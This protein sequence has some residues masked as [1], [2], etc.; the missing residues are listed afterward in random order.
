MKKVININFQGRV[1]PIEET[2][3]DMLTKYVESLRLFFANE[4]GRDEIINDIEGRI[5]ELFGETLKKGSTCIT[6]ADV[7]TII[8]SM[9]RPEDFDDD[10]AKVHSQLGGQEKTEQTGNYQQRTNEHKRLYRD[11]N[12]KVVAGVCSGMANYFNI[13]PVVVRILTLLF[14][15]VTLVP[16]LILWVAVPSS[17]STVIGSQR[18]RLFRD[19]DNKFVAGVCSG[20]SQYF[21]INIWI[22][23]VLFLLPFLSFVFRNQHWGFWD[24]PSIL[25]FSFSPTSLVVYIILWI[26]LPEA[27]SAADKLEMKGE[28]V[29]L[30]NIKTTIQGDLVGFK[31][32]AQQFGSEIRDKAQ[33]FGETFNQKGKQFSAEAEPVIKRSRRNLGDIIIL[34]VKIFAY[35]IVGCI[36][37]SIVIALF[38]M[39]VVVTSLLPQKDFILRDG[40]QNIFAWGTLILFVWVPIVGIVT[41]I[42]RRL[43]KKRG[44]ST[45][46]RSSFISLWVIGIFCLVGLIASLFRDF[47]YRNYPTEQVL[48]LSNPSVKKLEIKTSSFGKFYNNNWFRMEPFTMFD[49]DTV[50]VRNIRLRIVRSDNDS[51]KISVV[52]MSNGRSRQEAEQNATKINF[53]FNQVDTSLIVNKGIAITSTDKFRNQRLVV[54]VAVPEGKRININEKE[55]WGEGFSF[56]MGNG[57]NF[58]DWENDAE[59][60]S[61]WWQ[62]NV[63]Y[64]MTAKGLD[65]VYKTNDDNPEDNINEGDNTSDETIEQFRKSKEQMEREKEQKIRELQKIEEELQKTIDTSNY[66]YKPP[67]PPSPEMPVKKIKEIVR[68]NVNGEVPNGINDMMMIKFAL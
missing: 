21:A 4:E 37:I 65:K 19:P 40:L 30:N 67:V 12:H 10:E 52:K 48:S 9:G 54:T 27:K 8:N 2:A 15:G 60:E 7:N 42:I 6:D 14:L 28:K 16:Y 1:I 33:E 51:F 3:Y 44:N 20:L 31:D 45:I 35:F 24:F 57:N 22:P 47:K 43:A 58:F 34:L 41:Y 23:R 55:G 53:L 61:F 11:E 5:A 46:I 49:G 39:G 62:P 64:V 68:N 59:G 29:D 26:V 13:D 17:A 32:R 18:K 38:S 56:H 36:L 66:R 63:E 50:Y 25:S